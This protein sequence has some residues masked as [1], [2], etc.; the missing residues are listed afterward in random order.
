[1]SERPQGR[2]H[3]QA[4]EATAFLPRI[5]RTE[6]TPPPARPTGAWPD[7]VPPRPTTPA[8]SEGAAQVT[9]VPLPSGQPDI[10]VGP[11]PWRTAFEPSRPP[12]Q[13][14]QRSQPQTAQQHH[15]QP[16]PA[17]Q[18]FGPPAPAGQPD[19]QPP[20]A[21]QG[22]GP[23]APAGPRAAPPPQAPPQSQTPPPPGYRS[24]VEAPTAHQQLF[25]GTPAPQRPQSGP[26]ASHGP[27]SG[28]SAS[29]GPQPPGGH[30][31]PTTPLRPGEA[32]G[33]Q[34][35]APDPAGWSTEGP[36]ALIPKIKDSATGPTPPG[37]HQRP[38]APSSHPAGP[39]QQSAPPPNHSAG[40]HQQPGPVPPKHPAGPSQQP[41]PVPPSHPAGPS[42]ADQQR[43]ARSGPQQQ[44]GPTGTD[45]A[46]TALIPAVNGVRPGAPTATDST[47][48]MGAV[49]RAPKV[50]VP[51]GAD[52]QS[53]PPKP[54]R[55]DRVVQLRPEQTGEGYKSVYSELTRP[56][57]WSRVRTGLRFGGELLITFGLVVLL[58]AGYEI[59][60][61]SAIVDAHQD[62]LSQQLAQA[63][64]PETDPTVA[65]PA[66]PSASA[67]PKPPVQGKPI[68]GL[69]I[70]K[71]DKEW[72]VVEGVTQK[73]I[74]YAPG[75]YP[76]SVM[77]GQVGNF[78]VAGHRNRATFWRLDELRKGDPII[79]QSRDEWYVYQVTENLI[80]KPHQVEV[81]APVPGRPGAKPTKKMLTLTTCNPKFDNY[82]R[83]IIHAELTRTQSKDQG[84]PA[85][86]GA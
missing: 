14:P 17:G 4:D 43:A 83:L 84:R 54:R 69:Y 11:T 57:F 62:E 16:P 20:P 9:G 8:R 2:H 64:A 66:S 46:A 18:G 5:E 82:E 7:P 32:G 49:P 76:D 37:P 45:E 26:S 65:A 31:R 53:E 41:G 50:E 33:P 19:R 81:V 1:M 63:W 60:G 73:D 3:D 28:P 71:F 23:P 78:S 27:Q 21:G 86:L 59:W 13:G 74:R 39:H 58:F 25:G 22:F 10:P 30:Q 61:K 40:P 55:G 29:H 12:D 70:P 75:H 24:P 80:V 38:G 56:S 67:S 15:R 42:A 52:Q 44:T 79:V 34:R 68:A 48:L 47:A 36:T 77:P 35:P 85:E 51:E 6:P 72:I